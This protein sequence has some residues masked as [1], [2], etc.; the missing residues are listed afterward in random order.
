M[1]LR[2]SPWRHIFLGKF[3]SKNLWEIF[4]KIKKDK[5]FEKFS[6]ET[7]EK[8]LY[9]IKKGKKIAEHISA[10]KRKLIKKVY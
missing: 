10:C 4:L 8:T 9:K 2:I 6:A 1:T 5:N 3:C 7:C